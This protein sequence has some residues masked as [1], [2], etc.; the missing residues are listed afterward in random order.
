MRVLRRVW[1][2]LDR[3]GRR[4]LLY[5]VWGYQRYFGWLLGGQCRFLPSCSHYAEEA[6]QRGPLFPAV[7]LILWRVVRC[8]PL[9]RGGEDPVPEWMGRGGYHLGALD[10]RPGGKDEGGD[11]PGG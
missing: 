2:L 9:C 1:L 3:G 7:G 6:L 10:R 11:Q 4:L 5:V 8:Q